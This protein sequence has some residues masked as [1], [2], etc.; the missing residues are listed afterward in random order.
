MSFWCP[1]LDPHL[2]TYHSNMGVQIIIVLEL[3]MSTSRETAPK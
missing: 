3:G 2:T 1:F